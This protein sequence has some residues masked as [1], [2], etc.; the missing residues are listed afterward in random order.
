MPELDETGDPNIPTVME[1]GVVV[2]RHDDPEPPVCNAIRHLTVSGNT[3][4]PVWLAKLHMLQSIKLE[5]NH[6]LRD[7]D[8]LDG[9][10][11]I[12]SIDLGRAHNMRGGIG[13]LSR[14][15]RLRHLKLD[16][17]C[18]Q[19]LPPRLGRLASL[20]TIDAGEHGTGNAL[21]FPPQSVC[22]QGT[23]AI[24][25]YLLLFDKPMRSLAIAVLASRRR[26]GKRLPPELWR[27]IFFAYF[28]A[29]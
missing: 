4:P 15:R 29:E 14:C 12:R 3:I 28:E 17:P 16:V 27:E 7:L 23:D 22:N 6:W 8:F 13:A 18:V 10:P 1:S 21:I 25:Q 5:P 11:N 20:E 9:M 24:K 2:Y 26:G 19:A